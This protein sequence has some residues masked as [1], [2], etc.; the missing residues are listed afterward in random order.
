MRFK[1]GSV[2]RDGGDKRCHTQKRYEARLIEA[3]MGTM[4]SRRMMSTNQNHNQAYKTGGNN[5]KYNT[6]SAA[7]VS[8][9]S[10]H[11]DQ[12][13]KSGLEVKAAR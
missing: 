10:N 6:Y 12:N 9:A 7:L 1:R 2:P 8:A 5:Q 4:R 11:K 3:Y 13:E